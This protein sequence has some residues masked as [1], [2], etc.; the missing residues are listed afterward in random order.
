MAGKVVSLRLDDELLSW[1]T[2]YAASRGVSR[3]ALLEQGLRSFREDCESGVPEIKAAAARQAYARAKDEVQQGVGVCPDRA[4]GL[5]HVWK[6]PRVDP[7]RSCVHC[8]LHGR[9]PSLGTDPKAN[10]VNEGGGYFATHGR[11]RMTMFD[12]LK[13]P[14][15]AHGKAAK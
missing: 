7:F 8:G 5:G 6:S 11:E 9:E 13:A 10:G 3:T 15:S 4:P 12:G 14:A 2:G 1:A